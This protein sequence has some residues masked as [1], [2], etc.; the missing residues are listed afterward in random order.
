M[1]SF[2]SLRL[3]RMTVPVSRFAKYPAETS[4]GDVTDY[5]EAGSKRRRYGHREWLADSGANAAKT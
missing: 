2:A 1:R 5:E 3:L 4:I